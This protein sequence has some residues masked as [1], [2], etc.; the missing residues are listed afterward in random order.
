MES[1]HII[2]L[3]LK[4]LNQLLV[5]N[6]NKFT[7][8]VQSL[9]KMD[10][11]LIQKMENHIIQWILPQCKLLLRVITTKKYIVGMKYIMFIK[12]KY[13]MRWYLLFRVLLSQLGLASIGLNS[14]KLFAEPTKMAISRNLQI[15]IGEL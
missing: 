9:S 1:T 2:T 4:R 15:P 5:T 11:S 13:I 10:G 8:S 6:S 3:K 7:S 12:R 14:P